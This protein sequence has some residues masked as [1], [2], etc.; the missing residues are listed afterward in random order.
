MSKEAVIQ[1]DS[2]VKKYGD[3]AAVKNVQFQKG[4]TVFYSVSAPKSTPS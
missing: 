1:V 3:L 4:Y 2:L